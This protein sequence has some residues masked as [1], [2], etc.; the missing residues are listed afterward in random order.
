M[1]K[2]IFTLN[3]LLLLTAQYSICQNKKVLTIESF[4]Q[5][6]VFAH[7]NSNFF[8]T[9][10]EILFKIYCLNSLEN[11][12]STISKIGYIELI[13]ENNNSVLKQKLRLKNGEGNGTI[14]INQELKT[15]TYK[16]ISYTQW[17]RNSHTF[18]EE[19]IFIVNPFS[20]K[21][22][23]IDSLE[24]NNYT[25]TET[26]NTNFLELKTD[27]KTYQKREKVVLN[28][29]KKIAANVSISVRKTDSLHIPSKI[30]VPSFLANYKPSKLFSKKEYL[31]ELRGQLFYGKVISKSDENV[32]NLK[33]GISFTGNQKVTKVSVTNL[34]GEFYL[35]LDKSYEAEDVIIEVLD[36]P[37]ET[38]TIELNNNN[39]LEK[40]FQDFTKIHY[41]GAI[42][43]LVKQKNLH[44]Q[45]ENAY[46][47]VKQPFVKPEEN[48]TYVFDE[49]SNKIVYHLDDYTR[50]KT[51]KEVTV[52]ILQD[53]W[54]SEKDDTYNFH[55]RDYNLEIDP[56]LKTLL[57]VDGFIV[58]NHT[59]IVFF[60]ALKIK[61]IELVKEKYFFG[62]KRYQGI[63]NIETFNSTFKP[64]VKANNVFTLLKPTEEIT[65]FSP[66]YSSS[67]NEKIPDF[68]YQLYWNPRIKN[69][70][71][72]FSFY[73]SD[74][75]GTFEIIVEG[76]TFDGKPI[77]QKT[78]FSV[79]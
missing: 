46:N 69:T 49:N 65:L 56:D 31:P 15:G 11:T 23:K 61:T 24:I 36:H 71:D 63:I 70:S 54:I 75:T 59:D 72:N 51:L 57:I 13:D 35:N 74:V 9:G 14:F 60:D 12:M 10:E 29:D 64:N 34:K 55:V 30:T 76:L 8:I 38:F 4:P 47:E 66:N 18:F 50:F 20:D 78:F 43:E 16:F 48:N 53:V 21:L 6:K 26:K 27:Q 37:K 39:E 77:F 41:S 19:N 44:N 79:K 25:I 62:A 58:N 32:S 33:I 52:E 22:K 2:K 1:I 7:T 3:L 42:R 68:R 40:S 5:E 73:T 67:K 45:I 28:F 17:M